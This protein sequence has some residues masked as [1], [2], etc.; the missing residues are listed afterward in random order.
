MVDSGVQR[1]LRMAINGSAK[2]NSG[3]LIHLTRMLTVLTVSTGQHN[4]TTPLP[5]RKADEPHFPQSMALQH[6]VATLELPTR[7]A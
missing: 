4:V 3:E 2:S 6:L 1:A 7:S 5:R